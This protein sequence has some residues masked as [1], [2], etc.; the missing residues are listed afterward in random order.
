MGWRPTQTF[1]SQAMSARFVHQ[2][3]YVTHATMKICE[4]P[5]NMHQNG[6]HTRDTMDVRVTIAERT[7]TVSSCGA[8]EPEYDMPQML[9]ARVATFSV[10]SEAGQNLMMMEERTVCT[11]P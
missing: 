10:R 9:T 8:K 3:H 1:A 4:A 7:A 11:L 2:L 6:G 5:R